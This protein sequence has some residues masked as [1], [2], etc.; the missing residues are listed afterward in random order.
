MSNVTWA[1]IM[2]AADAALTPIVVVILGIAFAR[3]Q[4]RND[5]LL[6]ARIR[7]YEKIVPDLN[8]LM[9]Y[10]TFIG[11]WKEQSPVDIVALKR[12][13]D[14]NYYCAAPLFSDDVLNA[15][16]RFEKSCFVPFG[17]WGEAAKIISSPYCRREFWNRNG[18]WDP[19]LGQH[20][21]QVRRRSHSGGGT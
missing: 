20:V 2:T 7:H 6:Q 15:Y 18:G 17:T 11:T 1:D 8:T 5:Q 14:H 21:Q 16:S 10:L 4:N 12:R 9:C 19:K 3:R 13:L